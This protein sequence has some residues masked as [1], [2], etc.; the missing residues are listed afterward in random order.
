MFKTPLKLFVTGF[1]KKFIQRHTICMI[2]AYYD[3]ILYGI[4][5]QE[6]MSLKLM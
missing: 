4:E 6:K 2:D 5:S 1:K 3:Y